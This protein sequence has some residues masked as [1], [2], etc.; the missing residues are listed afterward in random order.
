MT[1]AYRDIQKTDEINMNRL[2]N[3]DGVIA[4]SAFYEGFPVLSVGKADFEHIAA[5]AEDLMR[6][7]AKIAEEM[8]IGSPDQIILETPDNKLIIAPCRDLFLC[9]F[10]TSGAN[11]G[12]IR[13]LLKNI[14]SDSAGG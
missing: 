1:T 8:K 2:A 12:L 10:T 14:Q 9:V 5:L 3:Q 6:S 7:G 11:L 4:V 13:V